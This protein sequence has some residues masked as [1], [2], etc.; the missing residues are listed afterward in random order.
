MS[1]FSFCKVFTMLSSVALMYLPLLGVL[2]ILAISTYSLMLTF[3]GMPG[4]EII[5]AKAICNMTLSISATR[6]TSHF[7][8]VDAMRFV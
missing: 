7:L 4:K 3:T 8:V 5:S 2:Y 6:F 1:L